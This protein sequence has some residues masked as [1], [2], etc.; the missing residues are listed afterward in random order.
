MSILEGLSR[1]GS[2]RPA[3]PEE[4]FALQLARRLGDEVNLRW[5]LRQVED[6]TKEHLLGTMQ[7]ARA[8]PAAA[9]A[10]RF[11]DLLS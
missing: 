11:H 8:G 1:V 3:T 10:E 6:H 5:Y 4:Y 9:V 2:F 7:R